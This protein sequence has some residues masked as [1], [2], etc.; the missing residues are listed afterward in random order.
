[1]RFVLLVLQSRKQGR[2]I[3]KPAQ[4]YTASEWHHYAT[5]IS[6][7]LTASLQGGN[8][9]SRLTVEEPEAQGG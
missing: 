1:M 5:Y 4:G 7:I 9:D 6:S 8:Y 2:E 3:N